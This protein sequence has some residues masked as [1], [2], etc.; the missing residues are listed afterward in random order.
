MLGRSADVWELGSRDPAFYVAQSKVINYV[1][2]IGGH[3]TNASDRRALIEAGAGAMA[4]H[5]AALIQLLLFGEQG[6]TGLVN[7]DGVTLVGPATMAGREG[8]VSFNLRGLQAPELVKRFA[9]ED[10][11]VHARISDG[12][13]G[14]I[15]AALDIPDCLRVSLC[16]Y[17]TTDEVRQLLRALRKIADG[18]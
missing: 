4:R 3:F 12:Y 7:F 5:E 2:W 15:L 11:R 1:C 14:H 16:H 6:L 18:R 8:I 9:A 10:I 13:S 17:N